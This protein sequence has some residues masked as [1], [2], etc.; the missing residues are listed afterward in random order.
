MAT[1][2]K[3]KKGPRSAKVNSKKR[4]LALWSKIIRREQPICQ[5]CG[6]K[7][8]TCAHHIITRQKAVKPFWFSLSYGIALCANCHSYKAHGTDVEDQI[9]FRDWLKVWLEK[10]GDNYDNMHL[11]ARAAGGGLK[12]WELLQIETQL[13]EVWKSERASQSKMGSREANAAR[14]VDDL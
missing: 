1:F 2:W 13:K 11:Y 12:E 6:M 10:R 14:G 5:C 4:C 7:E 3:K 8:A 9:A